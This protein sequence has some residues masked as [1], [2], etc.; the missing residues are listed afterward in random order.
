MDDPLIFTACTVLF[1][2]TLLRQ[3]FY[4]ETVGLEG[5]QL[6]KASLTP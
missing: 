1:Y 2:Y 5:G 6:K 3:V 4:I